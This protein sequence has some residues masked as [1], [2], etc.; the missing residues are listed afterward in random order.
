M[1]RFAPLLVLALLS[2][3]SDAQPYATLGG[4]DAQ[5]VPDYLVAPDVIDDALL[6]VVATSLPESISVP[7]GHPEFLTEGT[8]LDLRLTE[9]ADV[10]V[11]FVLEGAG[12]R[13]AL[14]FYTYDLADPPQT[15][16]EIGA[17]TLIFPNVSAQYSGGGLQ[18]GDKVHLGRFPAGTGIGW[19]L[20]AN[21]W[22][23]RDQR[24]GSG[25]HTVYSRPDFNPESDPA[26]QQHSVLL[27]DDARQILLLG[28][29]D[30]RRDQYS[31]EDFNDA[32]FYV[33]ANPY[34]AVDLGEVAVVDDPG[35]TTGGND[36]G[37]ESNGDVA[38]A[39]AVRMFERSL[40]PEARPA[41]FSA[42][43]GGASGAGKLASYDVLS[44]IPESG[45]LGSAAYV[46]TPGDLVGLTNAT[47][48][49]AGDYVRSDGSRLAAL[50]AATTPAGDTYD[51]TKVICDRLRGATLETV[52]HVRLKGRPFV[53]SVLRHPD[54]SLDQAISFVAYRTDAGWTVDSRYL[55]GEY[56]PPASGDEV[57]NIQVWASSPTYSIQ[58]ATAILDE[59]E[60]DGPLAFANEEAPLLHDVVVRTGTYR[61]VALHLRVANPIGATTLTV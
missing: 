27:R 47:A 39:L 2:A 41:P 7:D 14:G 36:G 56:R 58:L 19:F 11:T 13:N 50:F 10:W 34:T 9:E 1:T 32:V 12:Y 48:V 43:R 16:G 21:G 6:D 59:M 35:T 60:A 15:V 52:R 45:P 24:V 49:F 57:L 40:A 44:L 61:H 22:N 30:L 3:A 33:T 53:L 54:G 8:E 29:E 55:R 37:L 18:P 42:R 51:H 5:G 17:H 31:D 26:L 28:L 23:S 38:E 20:V 25:R 4:W 46:T